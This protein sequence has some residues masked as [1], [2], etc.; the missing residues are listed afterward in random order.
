MTNVAAE[1]SVFVHSF[2]WSYPAAIEMSGVF[3]G[4]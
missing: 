1:F 2:V 3:T 4:K